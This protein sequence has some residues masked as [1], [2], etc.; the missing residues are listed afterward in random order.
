MGST[1]VASTGGSNTNSHTHSVTSNVT[2]SNHTL[3]QP[4]FSVPGHYH[5]VSAS[6]ATIAAANESA[7]SH[8][9]GLTTVTAASLGGGS[10]GYAVPGGQSTGAGSAHTHTLSGLVGLV[11]GGSNGDAAFGATRTTDVAVSAHSVTNNAVTSGAA[12]DTENRPLYFSVVYLMRV[13]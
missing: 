2:V 12:S 1:A 8:P 10:Q 9:M 3:T 6:G 4:T 11:S 7:H 13:K 5:S